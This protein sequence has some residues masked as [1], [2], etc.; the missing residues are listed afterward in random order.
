MTA[1]E[2]RKK[3]LSYFA[4]LEHRVIASG[5]LIPDNDP[6]TLF[7]GS[8]MQVL[9]PYLL[10]EQH[11]EGKRLA[12]SQKC[13]RA[14]DMEE[15]GDN[16]HTTFFE[17]L[18][19]WSLGDY[20]KAE[21]LPWCFVFLTEKLG[22]DPKHLYVTVFSGSE[23]NSIPRD[24]ESVALWKS[25]FKE[26]GI[27]AK[28][29]VIGSIE[30]GSRNGMKGGRI[31]YYD[32]SKNWWSRV[33]LPDKMPEGEP[34]GPDSEIFYEF[35]EIKHD[36]AYGAFCHPNCDCGRFMEIGNS[37]FMEYQRTKTGFDPLP[38]RNVDFGGGLERLT[39][40]ANN[41]PDVFS[42]VEGLHFTVQQIE[43]LSGQ[44]YA[45]CAPALKWSFRVIADHIRAS[46]FLIGD[47][48]EPSN[49]EQGYVVR[50]L[51]RRVVR[52]ADML[53]ME[54]NTLH[55]LV[56][57]VV[58][59]YEEV[60]PYLVK[61]QQLIAEAIGAEEQ[62]FRQ[63]L[64]RGERELRKIVNDTILT[65]GKRL[66]GRDL[67]TMY[68]TYG[69]PV[70]LS[71]EEV[72]RV[73]LPELGLENA[74]NFFDREKI[75]EE[76]K[77]EFEQH[78]LLSKGGEIKKFHGG[79]ADDSWECTRLHTATHLL[80][81]S[82]RRVLGK[83]VFQKGSNITRDRLRFDFSHNEK[84]T[85]EQLEAIEREVNGAVEADLPVSWKEMTF[86]EAEK[87]G[88][89][90]LFEDRYG[91]K[92]KVYTVGDFSKEVCGGPHVAHTAQV[93]KVKIKKEEAVSRGIRRI[94]ATVS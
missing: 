29:V 39:A 27:D 64:V 73:I 26:K 42:T 38:Q 51:L 86:A 4:D 92:V 32:A 74:E 18:G 71:L 5:L 55:R 1:N 67:F 35:T 85:S 62:K 31:F 94:R 82:L 58:Q 24:D 30:E 56:R 77:Q 61:R 83:H 59:A 22:I 11:P 10:G 93:G 80:H 14:E 52:H 54:P 13:F 63:T 69:F 6:T 60:Y 8:G 76:F 65:A 70:E 89:L 41:N 57:P 37:V 43:Q 91:E 46:V 72:E 81:E 53:A 23:E 50:R 3:Y 88:A 79:L 45:N 25:L 44:S 84:V 17:M 21:Q 28:D 20:F 68:A 90:G 9:I 66:T 47:G 40:A 7:T 34:G 12:D 75:L 16:R 33:G 15:V 87:L 48:A 19:N 2:I 49:K 36:P 78:Q